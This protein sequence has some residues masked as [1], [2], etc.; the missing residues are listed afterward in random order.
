MTFTNLNKDMDELLNIL[1]EAAI[2][3]DNIDGLDFVEFIYGEE[4]AEIMKEG[5][6]WDEF[7]STLPTS[8]PMG[9]SFV[10]TQFEQPVQQPFYKNSDFGLPPF[11]GTVG[12]LDMDLD[13]GK[14]TDGLDESVEGWTD[15][16]FQELQLSQYVPTAALNSVSVNIGKV[17]GVRLSPPHIDPLDEVKELMYKRKQ[18]KVYKANVTILKHAKRVL[19]RFRGNGNGR[20]IVEKLAMKN[21]EKPLYIYG[22]GE[23]LRDLGRGSASGFVAKREKFIREHP[24]V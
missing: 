21:E 1:D 20:Y 22:I 5:F 11:D 13:A 12:Q 15:G 18:I 23:A 9:P 6:D 24:R 14:P 3:N 17:E 4:P 8:D 2:T 7:M 10:N 19:K 16:L